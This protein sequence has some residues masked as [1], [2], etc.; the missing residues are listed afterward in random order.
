MKWNKNAA[1]FQGPD[2]PAQ[3]A[4]ASLTGNPGSQFEAKFRAFYILPQ[5]SGS[6]QH[7]GLTGFRCPFD[8]RLIGHLISR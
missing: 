1:F 4:A 7:G 3:I 8:L 2:Q 5:L 6:D